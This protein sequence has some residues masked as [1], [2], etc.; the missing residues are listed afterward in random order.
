MAKNTEK[1]HEALR[2]TLVE[3]AERHVRQEGLSALRARKLAAEAGCAVGAI[4]NVFNDLTGL[5]LAVNGRTFHR[6][7]AHVSGA[8][9][10]LGDVEPTAKLVRMGEAYLGFAVDNP[11]LWRALFDVEMSSDTDVPDWYM[12]ELGQLFAIIAAP[13]KELNPVADA[14]QIDLMTRALFSSVHGIVLLG[15][16]RRISGVPQDRI[17]HMIGFMVR[18]AVSN[19]DAHA[20][21]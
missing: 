21:V 2:T 16:E 1:R 8:V 7:G 15:L 12:T 11:L 4:Y 5:V 9:S 19:G 17:E 14:Q 13:L 3:I 10:A 6:L 18:G 20:K